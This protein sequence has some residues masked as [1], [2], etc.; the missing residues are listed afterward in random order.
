MNVAPIVQ[1]SLKGPGAV[2]RPSCLVDGLL[3]GRG[4]LPELEIEPDLLVHGADRPAEEPGAVRATLGDS[5]AD[6]VL[7]DGVKDRPEAFIRLL[8]PPRPQEVLGL[9]GILPAVKTEFACYVRERKALVVLQ[10]KATP[11]LAL[12][13]GPRHD[14]GEV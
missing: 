8:S 4:E 10:H 7:L 9:D 14:G 11:P 12:R 1:S 3:Q 13:E 5:A 6:N 2:P